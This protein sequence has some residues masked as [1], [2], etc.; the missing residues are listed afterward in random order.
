MNVTARHLCTLT[1][2]SAIVAPAIHI[3]T[4]LVEWFSGGFSS[5]QLWINYISFIVIPFLMI[6]LYAVQRPNIGLLGLVGALLY[7][8]SFVYFAHTTLYAITENIADYESLW[9]RLGTTY[10]VHGI[11]MTLG[12]MAFGIATYRAKV[13]PRWTAAMF[14]AGIA[15]NISLGIVAAP[16]LFQTLGSAFRNMGLIAMGVYLMRG[17]VKE[18][19]VT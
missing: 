5:T 11:M 17:L 16:D 2:A 9:E 7:G 13:F 14:L 1:G 12:G 19:G 4:D 18:K 8:A 6:G 3:L 15:L 10:T